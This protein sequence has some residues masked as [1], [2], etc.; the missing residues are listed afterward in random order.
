VIILFQPISPT[1]VVN[2][3]VVNVVTEI[4]WYYW[5]LQYWYWPIFWSLFE[6]AV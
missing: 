5:L 4:Y 6:N 2:L 1:T 3:Y